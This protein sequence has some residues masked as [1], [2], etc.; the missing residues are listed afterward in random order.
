M[1]QNKEYTEKMIKKFK[2]IF[3]NIEIKTNWDVYT[4][5][6]TKEVEDRDW[7][8]VSVE[9]ID[10][11]EYLKNPVVLLNHNNNVEDIVWK[12]IEIKK[13]N[14]TILAKF[15]FADTEKAKLAKE[16]YDWW[17]LKASSIWFRVLER[18]LEN[19]NI[20]NKSELYEWSLVWVGA[21]QEALSL[22]QKKLD[23]A[24]KFWLIK[25]DKDIDKLDKLDNI[26][27]IGDEIKL[28][29]EDVKFIMNEIKT[30]KKADD[31]A[32][33]SDDKKL[34][35]QKELLQNIN[36]AT[37]KALHYFKKLNNTDE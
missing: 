14:N 15:I 1:I 17:Y 29:R 3:K 33:S 10:I 24:I 5:Q 19:P 6:I 16:L 32:I 18:S 21:N 11:N 23:K 7:E 34:L 30:L 26:K 4:M 31:K 22:D 36:K 35:E 25:E 8:I 20:I 2:N 37:S 9:W 13:Q 28:L 27:E 12:T